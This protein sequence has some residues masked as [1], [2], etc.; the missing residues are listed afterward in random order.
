VNRGE[1]PRQSEHDTA[2]ASGTACHALSA[3][4]SRVRF[5]PADVLAMAVARASEEVDDDGAEDDGE[6]QMLASP[7]TSR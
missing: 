2:G 3:L 5:A 7:R 6:I 4:K 1:R